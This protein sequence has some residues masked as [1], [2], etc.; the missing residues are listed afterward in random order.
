[1][2]FLRDIVCGPSI[3]DIG[4]TIVGNY[5]NGPS[6]TFILDSDAPLLTIERTL[7]KHGIALWGLMAFPGEC[8]TFEVKIGQVREA[9][10]ILKREG[11]SFRSGIHD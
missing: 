5:S 9:E 8:G 10:E 6:V 1:M 11:V 7:K 2:S 4:A 3:I